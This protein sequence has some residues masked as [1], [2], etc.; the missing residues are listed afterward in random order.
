MVNYNIFRSDR[1]DVTKGGLA[2]YV[3]EKLE[4]KEIYKINHRK[5]E[6][7]A[8]QPPEIHTTNIVVYRPPKKNK[9]TRL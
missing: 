8:I 3:Y 4:A 9:K 1:K 7:I 2:I 6:M 5:F